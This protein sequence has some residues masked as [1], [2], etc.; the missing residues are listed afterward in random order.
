MLLRSCLSSLEIDMKWSKY[1]LAL[2]LVLASAGALGEQKASPVV[3]D[4]NNWMSSSAGE[5][6]AFLIGVTNMLIAEAAYAKRHGLDAP[7]MGAAITKGVSSMKLPEIEARITSWYEANPDGRD[8]LVMGVL[9][10]NV[11]KGNQ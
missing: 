8:K 10:R 2:C 3:V 7:P 6:R 9:W 11:V 1:T 4:G 5:R